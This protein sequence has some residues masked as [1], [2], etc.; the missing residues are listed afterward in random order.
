MEYT[1]EELITID[2]AMQDSHYYLEMAYWILEHFISEYLADDELEELKWAL[3]ANPKVVEAA[4]NTVLTLLRLSLTE[5]DKYSDCETW[6]V[7]QVLRQHDEI[8]KIKKVYEE[9]TEKVKK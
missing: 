3:Q 9:D 7:N 1:K 4:L 5:L 6:T 2:D 8:M